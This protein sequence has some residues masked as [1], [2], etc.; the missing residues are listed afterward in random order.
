M[1]KTKCKHCN[2]TGK[3]IDMVAL[4]ISLQKEREAT[5]L[6]LAEVSQS[7][8]ISVGYLSDMEHG[9]KRW[10]DERIAIFRHSLVV[11]KEKS[12]GRA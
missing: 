1:K 11:N 5:G 3:V 9:R 2:G 4:G 6:T 8:G 7:M 10:S 12:D